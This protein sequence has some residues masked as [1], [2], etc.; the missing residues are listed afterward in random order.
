M[1]TPTIKGTGSLVAPSGAKHARIWGVG[2]FRPAR[3][4]PN[5]EI[6][7]LIDSS[8]EWIQERSGIKSRRWA[9]PSDTVVSMSAAA[10][11]D[12]VAAAG[13]EL[14]QIDAIIL[15]TVTHPY[16]TPA[17]APIVAFFDAHAS[18]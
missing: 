16:Q 9:D 1:S 7:D 5:S 3:V 8:D 17:A 6:V 14:A 12:A 18:S 15:A 4:V 10:A 13:L 2:G 11:R